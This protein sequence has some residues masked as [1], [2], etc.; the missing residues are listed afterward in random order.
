MQEIDLTMEDQEEARRGTEHR[1]GRGGREDEQ[2]A[3]GHSGW[4]TYVLSS[5]FFLSA[6]PLLLDL[7]GQSQKCTSKGM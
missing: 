4:T 1:V 7:C 2:V 3:K 6:A 5:A